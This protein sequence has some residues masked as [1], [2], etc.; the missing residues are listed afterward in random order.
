[1]STAIIQATPNGNNSAPFYFLF[2]LS[3]VSTGALWWL[4]DL[5]ESKREQEAFLRREGLKM[6]MS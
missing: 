3:V 6:E 5:G 2:G 4:V 1:M